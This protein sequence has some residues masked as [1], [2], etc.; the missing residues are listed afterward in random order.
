MKSTGNFLGLPYDL[1]LP[2]LHRIRQRLWNRQ[3]RRLLVPKAFGWGYDINLYELLR[4]L[5]LKRR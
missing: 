5:G 3:D 2:T 4:R 1:R